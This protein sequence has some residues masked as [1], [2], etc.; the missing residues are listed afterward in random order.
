MTIICTVEGKIGRKKEVN[1]LHIT[2]AQICKAIIMQIALD[3]FSDDAPSPAHRTRVNFRCCC[4]FFVLLCCL[5]FVCFFFM[6]MV[7]GVGN[8]DAAGSVSGYWV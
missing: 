3:Q 1:D 7:E 5:V 8:G 6:G 4:C 2:N